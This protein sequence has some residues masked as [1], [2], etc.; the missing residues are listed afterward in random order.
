MAVARTGTSRFA[1]ASGTTASV[2][3]PAG[4]GSGGGN[5]LVVHI[6]VEV[7]TIIAAPAGAGWNTIYNV[8]NGA[9]RYAAFWRFDDGAAGPWVFTYGGTN[10]FRWW[11]CVALSGADPTTPILTSGNQNAVASSANCVAPQITPTNPDC[12]MLGFF[13]PDGPC[14]SWTAP[15]GMTAFDNIANS[16]FA[17]DQ[18]LSGGAGTPYGPKTGVLGTAQINNGSVIAIQPPVPAGAVPSVKM[19]LAGAVVTKPVKV[20]IGGTVQTPDALQVK[21]G[22]TLQDII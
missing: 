12:F 10:T 15:A 18:L 4:A 16:V 13:S 8:T 6:A 22:G 21:V 19:K 5:I 7:A 9:R 17:A 3:R 11:R 20:K 2:T 14:A 1:A